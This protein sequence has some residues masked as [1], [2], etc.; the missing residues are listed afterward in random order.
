MQKYTCKDVESFILDVN[1]IT[2]NRKRWLTEILISN[3]YCK[4]RMGILYIDSIIP[5][6]NHRGVLVQE[7]ILNTNNFG[8]LRFIVTDDMVLTLKD[9]EL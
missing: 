3:K 5:I 2:E 8:E 4:F 6:Y 1:N 9:R 7:L